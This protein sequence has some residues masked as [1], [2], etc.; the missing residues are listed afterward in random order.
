VSRGTAATGRSPRRSQFSDQWAADA[1]GLADAAGAIICMTLPIP[2]IIDIIP[3]R[4]QPDAVVSV[5]QDVVGDVGDVEEVASES[6]GAAAQPPRV[7]S[8]GSMTTTAQRRLED[9]TVADMREGSFQDWRK[10]R[11]DAA[12]HDLI[13]GILRRF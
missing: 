2:G 9:R 12:R 6:S 7:A 10:A 8:N 1:A 3:T 13:H 11:I 5:G 4:L